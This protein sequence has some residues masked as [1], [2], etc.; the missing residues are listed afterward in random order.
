MKGYS[1]EDINK[2]EGIKAVSNLPSKPCNGSSVRE[3]SAESLRQPEDGKSCPAATETEVCTLNKNCFHYDYNVTGIRGAGIRG[4]LELWLSSIRLPGFSV[5][6]YPEAAEDLALKTDS[7]YLIQV[8]YYQR[9]CNLGEV[10]KLQ[11]Q[12]MYFSNH[13]VVC[14]R[15]SQEGIMALTVCSKSCCVQKRIAAG[16]CEPSL[17]MVMLGHQS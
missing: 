1:N 11:V 16:L 4:S 8:K 14:L 17:V 2:C 13:F 5:F 10:C 12:E 9:L 6:S 7:G 3:R 15:W